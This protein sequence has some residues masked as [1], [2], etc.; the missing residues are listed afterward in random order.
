MG[1]GRAGD[2]SGGAARPG[3]RASSPSR[4]SAGTPCETTLLEGHDFFG[5]PRPDPDRRPAGRG[6]LGPSG[7]AVGCLGRAGVAAR[8]TCR[9]TAHGHEVLEAAG[10]ARP[11]P[12]GGRSRSASRTGVRD[13]SLRFVSDRRGWWQPYVHPGRVGAGRGA[14]SLTDLEAEFHGPDWV[15]GQRTIAEMPTEH[16]SARMTSRAGRARPVDPWPR[17]RGALRELVRQPCVS[18]AALCAHGD[19]VALIGSTPDA[20]VH[21]LDLDPGRGARPF[22]PA[23]GVALGR[24][25]SRWGSPSR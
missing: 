24:R 11:S 7:H 8:P 6:R 12:V 25:M 18:I 5:T 21:R 17:G 9:C 13:G 3:P 22:A 2:P 10:P 19:G 14:H 16:W 1:A 23:A 15:L 20:A 4:H